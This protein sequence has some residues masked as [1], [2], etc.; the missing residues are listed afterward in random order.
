M[1]SE[2]VD[3]VNQISTWSFNEY[4]QLGLFIDLHPRWLRFNFFFISKFIW[5]SLVY[6][7]NN[8]R[9]NETFTS[10]KQM[11]VVQRLHWSVVKKTENWNDGKYLGDRLLFM[12]CMYVWLFS[13]Q[14]LYRFSTNFFSLETLGQLKPDFMWSLHG[15]GEWK[16]V[17][18]VYVTWPR[19]PPWPDMVKT[20]KNFLLLNQKAYVLETWYAALVTQILPNLFNWWPWVDLD[21]FYSKV[22]FGPSCFC[23]GKRFSCRF[24][25]S[26]WSL[27]GE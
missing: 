9:C 12:V 19:W 20:F 18:M 3:A 1:I 17:Q 25:R 6:K 4:Q 15:M 13:K 5:I 8:K 7:V 23:M 24:L 16:W 11:A 14:R 10:I 21:L 26:C 2:L 27:W 22:K